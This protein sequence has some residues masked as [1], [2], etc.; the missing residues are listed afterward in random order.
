MAAQAASEE[1]ARNASF[2]MFR[3]QGPGYFGDN[4]EGD[5]ALAEEEEELARQ[6]ERFSS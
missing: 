4:D 3:N 6:G 1:S 5:A 2:Q